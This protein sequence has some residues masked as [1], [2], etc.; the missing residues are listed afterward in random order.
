MAT[1]TVNIIGDQQ[2]RRT[3][4]TP[5]RYEPTMSSSDDDDEEQ[6]TEDVDTDDWISSSSEEEEDEDDEEDGDFVVDADV[7]EKCLQ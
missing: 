1:V 2:H 3:I 4:R 5:Q 7:C 6:K